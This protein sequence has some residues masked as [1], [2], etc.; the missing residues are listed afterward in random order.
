LARMALSG[1]TGNFQTEDVGG[2]LPVGDVVTRIAVDPYNSFI[3]YAALASGVVMRGSA[4]SGGGWAWAKFT[5]GLPRADLQRIEANAASGK[6]RV[7]TFGRG[8]YETIIRDVA[9]RAIDERV[10]M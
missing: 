1:A 6:L 10:V 9:A 4:D 3:L 8:A 5:V 7:G 2:G